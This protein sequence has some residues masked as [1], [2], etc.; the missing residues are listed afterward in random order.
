MTKTI[1][2]YGTGNMGRAM[3]Q[4]LIQSKLYEAKDILIYD[5]YQ[6]I[7]EKLVKELGVTPADGSENLAQKS[8]T[9]IFAVKPYVLPNLLKELSQNLTTSQVLISVAA[10]VNIS[11]IEQA[12]TSQHKVVRVMPNTPALVGEGMS[13][14]ACN[15]NVSESE[16]KEVLEIFNSFG[17]AQLVSEN[18]IDAVVGVS[19]SAPAYVYMFIEALADGAVLEGMPRQ[20]AYE[21]AAQTVLGSAKMVLE[22]KK[23]PGELKDMVT[24]PGGTTIEAVKVLEDQGFRSAVIN[25]VQAASKCNKRLS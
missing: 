14:L 18:L 11:T 6:P 21:F 20:Q 13:A 22:T 7:V 10:G 5:V 24:S 25:A 19:G 3:I 2:F 17:K 16:E 23:H 1:G 9:I 4:G 15:A 12:L 8:D